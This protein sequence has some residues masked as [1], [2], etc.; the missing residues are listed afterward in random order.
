MG[1]YPPGCTQEMHDRAFGGDDI[2]RAIE[3]EQDNEDELADCG[4]YE[5]GRMMEARGGKDLCRHCFA[6][7]K[8]ALTDGRH[9]L[10]AGIEARFPR[11]VPSPSVSALD[12]DV[13][14]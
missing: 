13:E 2:D 10:V 8:Q 11:H 12:R 9:D 6:A 3:D 14:F 4:H 1:A 7:I 5:L